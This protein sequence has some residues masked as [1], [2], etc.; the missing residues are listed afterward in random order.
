[1]TRKLRYVKI[2]FFGRQMCFADDTI[3][4][5]RCVW[6]CIPVDAANLHARP[7][8]SIGKVVKMV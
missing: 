2:D 5:H 7:S 6:T 8:E 1:M 3:Q 4:S